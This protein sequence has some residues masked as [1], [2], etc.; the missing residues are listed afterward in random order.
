MLAGEDQD[1][2]SVFVGTWNMGDA[3]PPVDIGSWI[4]SLGMGK[5][6][7]VA[8]S[9]AHDVYAF[10]TQVTRRGSDYSILSS[11]PPLPSLPPS[12][13]QSFF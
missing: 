11:F 7:P 8:L 13:T 5:T 3:G 1:I 9:Q 6:L 10:G 4:Q 2:I 12:P